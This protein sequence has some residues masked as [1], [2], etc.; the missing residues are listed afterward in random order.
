[1]KRAV[2]SFEEAAAGIAAVHVMRVY[3]HYVYLF[4]LFMV[5]ALWA[6]VRQLLYPLHVYNNVYAMNK[7]NS[8][9]HF[10]AL[11]L[12]LF[13][14]LRTFHKAPVYRGTR[15]RATDAHCT[16]NLVCAIPW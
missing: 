4:L 16:S 15:M 9:T 5:L 11:S 12:E 14:V 6:A 8:T 1:M 13:V 7:M 3:T 10:P 2:P